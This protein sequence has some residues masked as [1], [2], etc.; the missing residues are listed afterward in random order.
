MSECVRR[1]RGIIEPLALPLQTTVLD[2]GK[3]AESVE[4]LTAFM[5]SGAPLPDL[6]MSR[7]ANA[8]GAFLRTLSDVEPETNSDR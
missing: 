5:R 6:P 8:V 1:Y 2:I 7:V 4:T 3:V